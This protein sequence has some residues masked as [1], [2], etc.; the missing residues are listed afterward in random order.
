MGDT[1]I[2]PK[3][4]DELYE[5]YGMRDYKEIYTNGTEFIPL[6]RIKQWLVMNGYDKAIDNYTPKEPHETEAYPHRLYCDCGFTFTFNKDNLM[7]LN[8]IRQYNYCPIC[9]QAISWTHENDSEVE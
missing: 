6:F 7:I 1:F 9:G 3:T 4:L 8:E 2:M 5:Q